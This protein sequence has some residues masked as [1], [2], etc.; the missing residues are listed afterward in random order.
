MA[1]CRPE[2]AAVDGGTAPPEPAAE[3]P[4]S[5]PPPPADHQPFAPEPP[6]T[7]CPASS[8]W[9]IESAPESR[10]N[11]LTSLACVRLCS[12]PAGEFPAGGL[13]GIVH[14][15][16]A[17]STDD[18]GRLRVTPGDGVF[19]CAVAGA[20]PERSYVAELAADLELSGGE[21]RRFVIMADENAVF[22]LFVNGNLV[23]TCDPSLAAPGQAPGLRE[24]AVFE[25]N[26]GDNELRLRLVLPSGGP[27][28]V[29]LLLRGRGEAGPFMLRPAV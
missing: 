2:P 20:D 25:L 5:P 4:P 15:E 28:M 17:S 23:L 3:P 27:V 14:Q 9:R 6:P 22:K 24:S 10:L 18:A 12:A 8:A 26:P 1:G 16:L 19:S 7:V 21:S 11:Y 13:N 29:K